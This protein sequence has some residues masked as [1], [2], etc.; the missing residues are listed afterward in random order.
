M[1]QGTPGTPSQPEPPYRHRRNEKGDE[2][3]EEKRSEKGGTA[4]GEKSWDEKWRHDPINALSW[5][6]AF[7]WAGL[8]L[9]AEVTDWGPNTFSWWETWAVILA[10]AGVIF[11]IAA[12]IR[13]AMPAHRRP[14]TGNII[15]GLILL[16]VG[17]GELTN[18]GWGV[19]GAVLFLAIGV[20]IILT[21]I[22]RRRR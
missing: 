11:I 3:E 14:I 2:K 1:Q 7:I 13:L 6:L 16:A 10:G 8:G 15:F 5:A 20:I 18:W 4:R 22:F 17:L 21:G 12:L 19:L 9:L